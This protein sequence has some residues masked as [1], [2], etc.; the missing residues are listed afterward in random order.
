MYNKTE[1]G[2]MYKQKTMKYGSLIFGKENFVMVKYYQETNKIYEDYAHKNTLV[3]L[4]ENMLNAMVFDS[5][6]IPS[7]IIQI[8]TTVSVSSRSGWT[9]TFR[10]VPPYEENIKSNKVSVISILGASIIGLSEGDTLQYGLPGNIISLKI[11]KVMQSKKDI[12]LE[13]SKE[14]FDQILSNRKENLLTLNI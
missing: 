8:Y 12:K 14:A 10:L 4:T 2:D 6:D 7:D 11:E 5:N 3:A 13:M 9:E 1:K